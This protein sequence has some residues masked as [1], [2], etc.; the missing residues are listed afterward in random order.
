MRQK[1]PEETKPKEWLRPLWLL[2]TI[3]WSVALS[4]A[5]PTL[6]GYWLDLPG[7]FNTDPLLTFIGFGLGTIIAFYGLYRILRRFY[8][9]QKTLWENKKKGIRD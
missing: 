7:Q 8:K 2:F 5:L 9:E 3:G 1:E 6:M 4:I